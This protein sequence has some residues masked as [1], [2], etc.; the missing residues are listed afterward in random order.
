MYSCVPLPALSEIEL[1]LACYCRI[2]SSVLHYPKV[3]STV[4]VS[5]HH[6]KRDKLLNI[7][8]MSKDFSQL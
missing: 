1:L 5:T 4:Q 2:S 7:A 3:Q 8:M 6:A